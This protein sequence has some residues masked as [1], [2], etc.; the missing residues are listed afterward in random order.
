MFGTVY[1]P[2]SI[3]RTTVLG[4]F[5]PAASLG[6]DMLA[7]WDANRPDLIT[8]DGSNLV[9]SWRDIVAGYDAVQGTGADQP[10]WSDS[11]FNGAPGVDFDG[12]S[13]FLTCTDAALLAALPASAAPCELW[14]LGQQDALAADATLRPCLGYGNTAANSRFLARDVPAGANRGRLNVGDG[15]GATAVIGNAVDCSGRVVLRGEVGATQSTITVNGTVDDT[16]AGVPATTATR[17]RIGSAVA[18]TPTTFWNG[19]IVVAIVTAALSAAK[20]T[21]LQSYLMSRRG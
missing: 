12:T 11:S 10:V 4:G 5:D 21:A 2:G 18:A 17:F 19:Q 8:R 13:D 9:S 16:D 20:A 14:I 6:S 7:Y 15:V 1:S 3:W